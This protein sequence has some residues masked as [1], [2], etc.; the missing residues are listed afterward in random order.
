MS[1]F[2]VNSKKYNFNGNFKEY[3]KSEAKN[4]RSQIT[5]NTNILMFECL[6]LRVNFKEMQSELKNLQPQFVI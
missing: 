4:L 6:V 3:V 5:I 2:R 1:S